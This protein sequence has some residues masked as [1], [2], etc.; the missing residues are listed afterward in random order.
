MKILPQPRDIFQFVKRIPTYNI[1][2]HYL[3]NVSLR[4]QGSRWVA[5]CPFHDDRRPS[6]VI[7]PDSGWKCFGCGE[8]GDQITLVA[9]TFGIRPLQAAHLIA[10]DFGLELGRQFSCKVQEQKAVREREFRALLNLRVDV[11]YKKLALLYRCIFHSLR[12]FEDYT[13]MSDLVHF[14]VILEYVLDELMS[15]DHGR[16]IEALRY[17]RR[18]LG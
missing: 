11:A 16:Q 3:P 7:F 10:R 18:W 12:T 2:R 13:R 15:R 1:I 5:R 4:R 17:A 8:W 9:K 6:F 14:Q